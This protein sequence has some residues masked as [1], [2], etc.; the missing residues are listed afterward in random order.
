MQRWNVYKFN[1]DIFKSFIEENINCIEPTMNKYE[2]F[3]SLLQMAFSKS[4]PLDHRGNYIFCWSQ[5]RNIV[6]IEY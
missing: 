6:L 3:V 4:M 5:G 2:H 1:W